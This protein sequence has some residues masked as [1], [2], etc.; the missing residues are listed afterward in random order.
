MSD[1]SKR[2]DE[3]LKEMEVVKPLLPE[4][5]VKNFQDAIS[6]YKAWRQEALDDL[7]KVLEEDDDDASARSWIDLTS[8]MRSDAPE[9]FED[10]LNNIELSTEAAADAYRWQL[11]VMANEGKFFEALGRANAAEVRDYL[12]ANRESLKAYTETLDQKWRAIVDEGNKLQS[13][14]KKLYEEMLS[15]TRRIVDEL[16][17]ADRTMKEKIGYAGTFPLLAIEKHGSAAASLAGL[18]DG[19]GEAAEK[20]A[21]YAREKMQAWLESNE[22]LHGRVANYRA[23]VQAEK[24]G[25]LPLFKET[26]R[27]V[28]E[29]WDKNNLDR[30]RDWIQ[31]FRTSL[32][33]EWVTACPTYGQQDDAKSFYEAAFERVEEHFTAVE[34]VAKRFEEK[35]RGVFLGALAPQ[36]I[37]ELV[38]STSWRLNAETLISIRTPEIINKLLDQLDGYYE[39]SLVEPLEQLKGK[40]DALGG[41]A[42]E[43]TLQAVDRARKR[44]E[45]SIGARIT[46]FRSEVGASLRWFEPD[47]LKKALDRSELEDD[48][49]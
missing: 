39:E 27:Q 28:Y 37:D 30:A 25:L 20:A 26:R 24:G 33:N 46:Q 5:A 1:F 36:T 17:Q 49:E 16:T 43:Q 48:L 10:S 15:A 12:C 42:R 11:T 6:K 41:E 38:D 45:D 7:L 19:V 9:F 22:A 40:A 47:E 18:P 14:E 29:Y 8:T 3:L 34:D 21:E 2:P 32:E 23:L 35:W 31:R 13:E 44:V 4:Q